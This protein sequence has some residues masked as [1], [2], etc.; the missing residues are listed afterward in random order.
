MAGGGGHAGARGYGRGDWRGRGLCLKSTAAGALGQRGHR[1]RRRGTGRAGGLFYCRGSGRGMWQ[2]GEQ[3]HAGRHYRHP[4][5][6][7]DGGGGGGAIYRPGHCGD[8]DR[9][10]RADYVGGGIAALADGDGG[11]GVDGHYPY[12]ADFQRGDCHC[13]IAQRLGGRRGHGGLLCADGG[14]CGDEL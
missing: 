7:V 13:P 6:H 5:G 14:L 10:R 9:N 2:A 11:G 4:G 8:D 12:L 1:H 3:N